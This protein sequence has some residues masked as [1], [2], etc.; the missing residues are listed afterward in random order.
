MKRKILI[1]ISILLILTVAAV[2]TA[3]CGS[4]GDDG[5]EA[6]GGGSKAEGSV[7][8][9]MKSAA[10]EVARKVKDEKRNADYRAK[11][12]GG[13]GSAAGS[14]SSGAASSSGSGSNSSGAASGKASQEELAKMEEEMPLRKD[15]R[16]EFDH[17]DKSAEYQKYIVLHDTEGSGDADTVISGWVNDGRYIASHF[18][19]NK[20][21]TVVQCV[22]MDRIA[23]HAGFGDTGHNEQYGVTDESRDDKRGTSPIGS[24][25]ADYGMNSYS[26]GIEMVHI[27]GEEYPE[28]QLEA[29][30]RLIA[31]IDAYYGSESDIIDHKMWRTG[32]SDTSQEFAGYLE[33]YR[34]HRT[35][36]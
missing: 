17:G 31:Y 35:H 6:K 3:A 15:F 2:M 36:D 33:N 18:I 7:V 32:N 23:H 20:D 34:D 22:P 5:G 12:S 11:K 10:G 9:E 13:S 29:V 19:V 24:D 21:G 8:K 25:M 30:D 1:T 4:G 26:V 27:G 14:G 16:D 28:A